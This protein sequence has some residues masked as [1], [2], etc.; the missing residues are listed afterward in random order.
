MQ[1][2]S[3]DFTLIHN[4]ASGDVM[5]VDCC[6]LLDRLACFTYMQASLMHWMLINNMSRAV[7]IRLCI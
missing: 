1:L 6:L 2:Q 5:V 4:S 3:Y 7:L